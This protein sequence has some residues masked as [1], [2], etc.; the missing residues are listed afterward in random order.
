MLFLLAGDAF[1]LTI[2]YVPPIKI[3]QLVGDAE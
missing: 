1:I 2:S 3:V